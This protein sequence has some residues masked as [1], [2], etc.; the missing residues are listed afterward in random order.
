MV[1]GTQE[2]IGILNWYAGTSAFWLLVHWYKYIMVIGNSNLNWYIGTSTFWLLVRRHQCILVTGICL[3]VYSGYMLQYLCLAARV[4]VPFGFVA[5][6]IRY[7]TNV[8][9]DVI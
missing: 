8:S 1:I 5:L 9:T 2:F 6:I 4:P 3:P 7:G